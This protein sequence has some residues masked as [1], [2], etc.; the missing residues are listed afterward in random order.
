MPQFQTLHY[1][2]DVHYTDE[3]KLRFS[4]Q[5]IQQE[6]EAFEIELAAM[7]ES[8]WKFKADLEEEPRRQLE[9]NARPFRRGEGSP[10]AFYYRL[11]EVVMFAF[12]IDIF[13]DDG[14]NFG[15]IRPLN[16]G[17]HPMICFHELEIPVTAA[18]GDPAMYDE[19]ELE[20]Y[21][22]VTGQSHCRAELA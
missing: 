10:A 7:R 21:G 18:G 11:R 2:C 15:Q 4:R 6:L 12:P 22:V 19:G 9:L 16:P 20:E 5:E 13:L 1:L 8:F 14:L 3:I 17:P